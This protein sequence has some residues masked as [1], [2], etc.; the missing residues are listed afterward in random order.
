MFFRLSALGVFVGLIL[1]RLKAFLS[2][3]NL[4]RSVSKL[5]V[6][7]GP[8]EV[9]QGSVT[10][11][12]DVNLATWKDGQKKDDYYTMKDFAYLSIGQP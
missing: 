9:T 6:N 5:Q 12:E 1:L 11:S 3:K 4:D 8:I 2:T 7:K 10:T